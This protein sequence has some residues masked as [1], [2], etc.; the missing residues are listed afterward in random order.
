MCLCGAGISVKFV[1]S[2]HIN[3]VVKAMGPQ[4]KIVHIESP[5]N[6]LMHITDIRA[7]ATL[8]H[9]KGALLTVDNTILTPCVQPLVC[10]CACMLA[11]QC[12]RCV[13]ASCAIRVVCSI[14]SILYFAL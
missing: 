14:F 8:V 13:A 2:W 4:T 11:K 10:L 3:N 5:S 7:L 9:S 12:D 6:P 1:E